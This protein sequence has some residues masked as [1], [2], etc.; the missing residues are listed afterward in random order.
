MSRGCCTRSGASATCCGIDDVSAQEAR[1]VAAA[2]V[3]VAI[4]IAACVC[5]FVV[6]NQLRAQVDREL[7][8]QAT[9]VQQG[10]RR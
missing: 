1:L 2:A 9:A 6:R 7:R 5:Y 10:D 8:E 3:G 4:V